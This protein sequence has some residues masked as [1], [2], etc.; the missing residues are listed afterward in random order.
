MAQA[1]P[2]RWS[3]QGKYCQELSRLSK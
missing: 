3:Q 1:T 2:L